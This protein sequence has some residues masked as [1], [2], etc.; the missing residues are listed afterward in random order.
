MTPDLQPP[1]VVVIERRLVLRQLQSVS[2][3]E[4]LKQ[5]FESLDIV[6]KTLVELV[7]EHLSQ[8]DI[9][10]RAIQNERTDQHRRRPRGDLASQRP[11]AAETLHD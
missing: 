7:P 10:D 6:M 11:R 5:A 9:D 1:V 4:R 8:R 3:P 2:R